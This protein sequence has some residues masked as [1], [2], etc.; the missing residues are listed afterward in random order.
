MLFMDVL[1]S[2]KNV[3]NTILMKNLFGVILGSL[4]YHDFTKNSAEVK[5]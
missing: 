4:M 3:Q 5:K 1:G 2:Y